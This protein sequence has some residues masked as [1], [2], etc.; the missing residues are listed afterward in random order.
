M[1]L[2]LS[3][4]NKDFIKHR[5]EV[6][7]L[8]GTTFA[9]KTTMG[10]PKFMFRIAESPKKLHVLAGLDLGTIEKNIINKDLGIVDIF[11][12]YIEYN[13]SGKGEHTL[14]HIVYTLDNGTKKII[15]VVGYDNK[16]RWK[17]VLGGQYGCVFIDE[18]NVADMEFVREIFM[19]RDYLIATLNPDDPNLPIYKEYINHSRPLEKYADDLPEQITNELLKVEPKSGWT[20]WFFSFDDNLGLD[21]EKRE[22]IINS[23]PKGTKQYKN[24]IQGL[25]GRHTGLCLNLQDK[26]IIK[27]K[28]LE[29]WLKPSNKSSELMRFRL[30]AAGVDTSYSR[31]SDDEISFMFG[32]ITEKGK[33]IKIATETYNNTRIVAAGQDPIA[34]S[35]LPPLLEA[36]LNRN[37]E[38]YGMIDCCYIDSADSATFTE[39]EKYKRVKGLIYTFA[40]SYKKTKIIDRIMLEN[41]WLASE[42]EYIVEE[43]NQ[44][45]I[46]ELNTYSWQENKQEPEDANDHTINSGQYMWL[47][48]KHMIGVERN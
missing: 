38:K 22:Q 43:D 15:Y 31:K 12:G 13:P 3:Q 6:E 1:K 33:L 36:F 45:H 37:V 18:I 23:V 46:D 28:Q 4:K 29:E 26:N 5:A 7:F 34:P 11:G 27:R 16:A 14:P 35:D 39:I 10:I 9:G 32:G 40:P 19:R 47:P 21:E 8:E 20:H 42:N 24:K 2:L 44:A 30:F 17:K 41:G 25:R 48:Y